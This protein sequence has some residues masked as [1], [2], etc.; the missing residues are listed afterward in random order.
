M[1]IVKVENADEL[2]LKL[3]GELEM[4]QSSELLEEVNKTPENVKKMILDF[5][6]VEYISSAG[7]R[8]ILETEKFI[9]KRGGT[10]T[11]KKLNANVLEILKMASL[12]DLLNIEN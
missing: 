9:K 5:E 8:A 2:T 10:L 4:L 1:K 12:T 11:L 6:D 3:V 7:V